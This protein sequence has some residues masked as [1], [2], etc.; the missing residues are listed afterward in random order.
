MYIKKIIG[1]LNMK[2]LLSKNSK[3]FEK[4]EYYIKSI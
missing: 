1:K 2:H 3:E 4:L